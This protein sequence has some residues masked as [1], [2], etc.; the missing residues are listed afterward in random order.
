MLADARETREGRSSQGPG[1]V[2][3]GRGTVLCIQRVSCI[4]SS[5]SFLTNTF[6]AVWQGGFFLSYLNLPLITLR[7]VNH[8]SLVSLHIRQEEAYS[9]SF[10][11]PIR[12]SYRRKFPDLDEMVNE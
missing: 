5:L 7:K 12:Q 3:T 9:C 10:R 11:A 8:S 1:I 2:R 6:I 4:C